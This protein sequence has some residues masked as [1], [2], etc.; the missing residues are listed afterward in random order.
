MLRVAVF[1]SQPQAQT[2]LMFLQSHG[3]HGH[4]D[5]SSDSLLTAVSLAMGGIGL[6]V[7]ESMAD[8]AQALLAELD[9]SIE[10]LALDD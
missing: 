4:L 2:A 8:E 6:W 5:A 9:P 3:L 10:L 1:L 7:P